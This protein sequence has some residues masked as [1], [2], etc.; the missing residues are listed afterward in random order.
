MPRPGSSNHGA[1]GPPIPRAGR[2]DRARWGRRGPARSPAGSR[3]R[4]RSRPA[5]RARSA[6]GSILSS[7]ATPR[8]RR[9]WYGR[10]GSTGTRRGSTR[11]G[12][13]DDPARRPGKRSGPR[14]ER[15][16]DRLAGF[17]IPEPNGPLL[18]TADEKPAFRG[19]GQGGHDVPVRHGQADVATIAACQSRTLRSALP[20]AMDRP[21]GLKIAAL[22]WPRC[23]IGSP[24]GR[25]VSTSQSRAIGSLP[26]VRRIRP[27]G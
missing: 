12:G 1:S 21:S 6:R 10:R 5:P 27:S 8:T 3:A 23:R 20:V 17:D 13:D 15:R 16:T 7:P 18:A 9:Y 11:P 14:G 25:P 26:A 22:T 2:R 19:E 4:V 24:T